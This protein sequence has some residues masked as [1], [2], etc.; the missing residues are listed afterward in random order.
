MQHAMKQQV[1]CQSLPQKMPFSSQKIML[2]DHYNLSY[3]NVYSNCMRIIRAV[4]DQTT[5]LLQTHC[6][7]YVPRQQVTL[8]WT[9]LH[10]DPKHLFKPPTHTHVYLTKQATR[11]GEA[12]IVTQRHSVQRSNLQHH[13]QLLRTKYTKHL[14][15]VTYL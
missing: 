9:T 8:Q 13:S 3:K 12:P 10:Y 1:I 6:K 14:L 7:T 4:S 15:R 2:P 5:Q 11:K